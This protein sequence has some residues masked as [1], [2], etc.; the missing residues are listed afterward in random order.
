[1]MVSMTTTLIGFS[2][3]ALVSF[4]VLKSW[5]DMFGAYMHNEMVKR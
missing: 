3:V 4:G 5:V 2:L 1:M